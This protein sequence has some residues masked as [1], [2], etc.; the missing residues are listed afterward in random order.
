M[1][2]V[3]PPSNDPT[4]SG[5]TLAPVFATIP[6]MNPRPSLSACSSRFH[7]SGLFR[8][9]AATNGGAEST[10]GLFDAALGPEESVKW[11]V[12]SCDDVQVA[13]PAPIVYEAIWKKLGLAEGAERTGWFIASHTW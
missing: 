7:E 9:M 3:R 12:F 2:G 4:F 5:S 10:R 1:A 13:K 6:R 8:L 11:S